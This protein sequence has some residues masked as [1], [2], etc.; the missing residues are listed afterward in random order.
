M[1]ALIFIGL[2]R[3]WKYTDEYSNERPISY[4]AM[5]FMQ[6]CLQKDPLNRLSTEELY[7]L[8]FIQNA[9]NGIGKYLDKLYKQAM[10]IFIDSKTFITFILLSLTYNIFIFL[11]LTPYIEY[12]YPRKGHKWELFLTKQVELV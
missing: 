11:I 5:E 9:Y 1:R 3:L 4:E 7:E 2:R 12:T 10:S 8:D 6:H